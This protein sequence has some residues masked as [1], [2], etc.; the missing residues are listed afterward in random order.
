MPRPNEVASSVSA[1][2]TV[3]EIPAL[4]SKLR[5]SFNTDKTK[6][7]SWR[8]SQL[9]ALNRM[10][11]EGRDELARSLF[12]D[13]RCSP[14][15]AYM[16]QIAMLQQEIY[17]VL[18]HLDEWMAD[19]PVATNLFNFPAQSV[20]K[21]DPLGV[22]LALGAWNYNILLTLSPLIGAIAAGN[23]C[24]VKP[25]SY[26]YNSSHAM[27]RLIPLYMDTDCIACV[28]GNRQ[29]TTAILN[30]KFDAMFFTGSPSVGKIVALAAAKQLCPVVLE[31]GGK[32][33]CIV[34]ESAKGS[35]TVP[36]A[37]AGGA[38]GSLMVTARRIVWGA[39]LNSGQ[40]CVR[41]DTFFVHESVVDELIVNMITVMREFYSGEA[42]KS[43]YYGRLVNE[44]AFDRLE[45][46]L[47]TDKKYIAYGGSRKRDE[48]FIEPTIVNFGSDW[49]AFENSALMSD[50]I[51]GP[52]LPFITY[53]NLDEQVLPF[54]RARPKPLALY[55]FCNDSVQAEHVLC[56]T[57]SGAAVVNDVVVHLS[58]PELPFGGV[59]ESGLGSYHGKRTFDNFS[60]HKA[61]LKRTVIIDPPQRYAP[62]TT[63][64]VMV[65]NLAF[66]P[67]INYYFF[68]F[69]H[70]VSDKKN[71]ALALLGL[72]HV[73]NL[74]K[75]KL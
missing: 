64:K 40:T 63:D 10:L 41:P 39:L 16:Q 27:V 69:I 61:V 33:P 18:Q 4:V 1:N 51:F 46:C 23:C 52:I 45:Q 24:L 22:V 20:V 11:T 15:E 32:S 14:F 8:V 28:E 70:L 75:S 66:F 72:L 56:N 3:E 43:E 47:E 57:S 58:N 74:W 29:I 54:I 7:K 60:H 68:K 67:P 53:T 48:L 36:L 2:I 5:N 31:L 37:M 59:Q 38:G 71:L 17:D 9:N 44:A 50:E 62:Y 19:E 73:R 26:A 34:T 30:E 25:G 55:L 49:K 13:M 6:Q 35:L 12:D 65:M 42:Y 21:K